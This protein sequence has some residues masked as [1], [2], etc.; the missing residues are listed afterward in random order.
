MSQN[1]TQHSEKRLLGASLVICAMTLIILGEGIGKSLMESLPPLEVMFG[2]FV[3]HFLLLSPFVIFRYRG[4]LLRE[5]HPRAQIIRA[6]LLVS[7]IMLFVLSISAIPLARAVAL[8]SV[9]PFI[10]AALSFAVLG[11]RVRFA[12][13][14]CIAG[15]FGGVILIARPDAGLEWHNILALISSGFY[16]GF[17]LA[18][19]KLPAAPAEVGSLYVAMVGTAALLPMLFFIDT[20]PPSIGETALFAF[21]GAIIAL[22]HCLLVLAYNYARAAF[23]AIFAYSEIA[24][25]VIFGWLLHGDIPDARE[26]LGIAVIVVSGVMMVLH[27]EKRTK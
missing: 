16:A 17:L 1:K 3:A 10:V 15:G 12:Q 5:F 25:A 14:V 11:E 27:G 8:I 20:K 9:A 22:A 6:A 7:S 2:R 18:S 24:G 23:L 13:F 21:I 19:R 26:W 4:K